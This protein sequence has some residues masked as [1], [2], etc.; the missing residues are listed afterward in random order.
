MYYVICA[1]LKEKKYINGIGNVW[2]TEYKNE[3]GAP[4][5][6]TPD[7]R[8][9]IPEES[10]KYL[11]Y[12]PPSYY[13]TNVYFEGIPLFKTKFLNFQPI[14]KDKNILIYEARFFVP[15]YFLLDKEIAVLFR[16]YYRS[17]SHLASIWIEDEDKRESLERYIRKNILDITKKINSKGIIN[18]ENMFP[19][20]FENFKKKIIDL[21]KRICSS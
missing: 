18:I 12:L 13:R 2:I 9:F 7:K 8:Y 17:I 6:L 3:D 10:G 19:E 20:N 1:H 16:E 5:I 14:V 4:I 11:A 15:N 21:V